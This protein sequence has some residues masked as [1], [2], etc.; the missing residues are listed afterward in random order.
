MLCPNAVVNYSSGHVTSLP[1]ASR[2][3]KMLRFYHE[4][5]A[6]LSGPWFPSRQNDTATVS[7]IQPMHPDADLNDDYKVSKCNGRTRR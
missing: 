4:S 3:L 1:H 7:L 5:M 2:V 6:S